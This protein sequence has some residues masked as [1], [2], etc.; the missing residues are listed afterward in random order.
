MT[1]PYLE[2]PLRNILEVALDA[3]YRRAETRRDI[4]HFFD[5][6]NV[7]VVITNAESGPAGPRILF[8][9]AAFCGLC[10]Y[11]KPELLGRT[12]KLLQ[13]PETDLDRAS[14]FRR[15]LETQ[16]QASAELTNY[17]SRNGLYDVRVIA[18]KLD[19][20]TRLDDQLRVAVEARFYSDLR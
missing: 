18:G 17:D 19:L 9:N 1:S 12:P 4:L 7:P 2:G 11:D 20:G 5:A 3:C 8:V 14:T 16:G 13:G 6:L 15:E 10:A